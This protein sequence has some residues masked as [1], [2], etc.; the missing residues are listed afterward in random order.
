MAMPLDL[1]L[2]RHGE[3]EGNLADRMSQEGDDSAFTSEFRARHSSQYRLTDVGR[4]QARIAGGWI[5]EH[6][7]GHFDRHL[8][9]EYVRAMETAALLHLPRA[10]WQTEFY[11]RERDAG[12]LDALATDEK[13]RRFPEAMRERDR[14][15]FYWRPPGGESL[16]EV[17][18]R[19]DRV[20]D[21]LRRS[22]SPERVII[23]CHGEVMRAFRVRIE[24]IPQHRY[25]ELHAP[26]DIRDQFHN[27]QVLHYTRRDPADAARVQDHLAW[28]RSTCPWDPSLSRNTWVPVTRPRYTD[29]ELLALAE[30]VPRLIAGPTVEEASSAAS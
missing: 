29:S 8:T 11:L 26:S 23:V 27:C 10:L 18:L 3:S 7:G 6:L 17:C 2:V 9:S 22:P 30:R 4:E 1:V 24:R 14:D 13:F 15:A 21:A 12:S 25:R 19:V 5:R 16:A 20:L 28:M